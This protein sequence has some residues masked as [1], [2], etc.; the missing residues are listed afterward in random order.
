MDTTNRSALIV[1]A[2][3]V[4]VLTLFYGGGTMVGSVI[5]NGMM[6][7]ASSGEVSWIWTSAL[8]AAVMGAV[9]FFLVFGS[10]QP[11]EQR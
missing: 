3:A 2:I 9:L 1:T 7:G 8:L 11:K 5:K 4:G 10:K 6:D